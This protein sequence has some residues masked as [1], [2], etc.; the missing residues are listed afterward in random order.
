MQL[1]RTKSSHD[2]N[3]SFSS[4]NK[5]EIFAQETN[6][7]ERNNNFAQ[8][9]RKQP[10]TRGQATYTYVT[11]SRESSLEQITHHPIFNISTE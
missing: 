1:E 7:N 2:G 3:I 11:A 9:P 4:L 6:W 8:A 10:P 5:S